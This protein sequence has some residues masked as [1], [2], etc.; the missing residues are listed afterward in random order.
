M[1][2]FTRITHTDHTSTRDGLYNVTRAVAKRMVTMDM[3]KDPSMSK[4]ILI[5]DD[6][7][8]WAKYRGAKWVKTPPK[9]KHHE[10][11]GK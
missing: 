3:D 9:E 4:A 7:T 1:N 10:D 6:G 5:E 11:S 8:V 2:H